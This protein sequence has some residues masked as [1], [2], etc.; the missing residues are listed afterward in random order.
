MERVTRNIDPN[1]L[2]LPL[3]L[4]ATVLALLVLS[5]FV[6]APALQDLHKANKTLEAKRQE[7]ATTKDSLQTARNLINQRIGELQAARKAIFPEEDFYQFYM[8]LLNMVNSSKVSLLSLAVAKSK[9][10]A[11]SE[12]P[13]E[14]SKFGIT[15]PETSSKKSEE[16]P[17]PPG[18][19][20]ITVPTTV[21]VGAGFFQLYTFIKKLE[22]YDKLLTIDRI[23]ISPPS[24][25]LK[26]GQQ[27]IE[28]VLSV[29]AL[30]KAALATPAGA[31]TTSAPTATKD[32][33]ALAERSK[34][35]K[36]QLNA[37]DAA[38][39]D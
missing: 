37:L 2:A 7:L 21:D 35:T 22:L 23:A 19:T 29:Y 15:L 33:K 38:P 18:M 13:E 4:G 1:K 3:T 12:K 10:V 39:S 34:Q 36:Q 24:A 14:K 5:I 11:G 25:T 26:P 31:D 8:E 20:L 9:P 30:P 16:S 6:L 28:L 17:T 27:Q 32:A